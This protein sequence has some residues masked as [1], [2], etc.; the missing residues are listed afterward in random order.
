MEINYYRRA[1]PYYSP[2]PPLKPKRSSHMNKISKLLTS[3]RLLLILYIPIL[4]YQIFISWFRS[5]LSSHFTK[6]ENRTLTIGM[7]NVL[8][9]CRAC[10]VWALAFLCFWM[11]LEVSRRSIGVSRRV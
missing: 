11:V 5:E 9:T 4:Y 3:I 7:D 8:S 10:R 1:V 6:G 2:L